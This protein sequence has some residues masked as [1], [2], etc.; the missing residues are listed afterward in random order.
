MKITIEENLDLAEPEVII[1][2]SVQNEAVRRIEAMLQ[3]ISRR[4]TAKS[5][6]ASFS[7]PLGEILYFESVDKRTFLYTG[8]QVLETDLRLYEAGQISSDFFRASRSNV[9]NL[10]RVQSIQPVFGSRA[11]L[12]MENGERVIVSRQYYPELKRKLNA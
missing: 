10:Q 11:E 9:V 4:I 8:D 7:V 3:T 6:Q 1:R 2:C 12:K 5:G